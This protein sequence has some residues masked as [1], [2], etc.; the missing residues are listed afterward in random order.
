MPYNIDTIKLQTQTW[1]LS[2][3]LF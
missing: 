2:R 1:K 3:D